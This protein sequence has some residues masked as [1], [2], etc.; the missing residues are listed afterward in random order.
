MVSVRVSIAAL[1]NPGGSLVVNV[2]NTEPAEISA[3]DSV[4]QD[5]DVSAVYKN[6]PNDPETPKNKQGIA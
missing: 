2:N 6:H 1:Q 5:G 3:A 4:D